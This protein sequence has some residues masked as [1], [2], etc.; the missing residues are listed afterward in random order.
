LLHIRKL[1][2]VGFKSFA[3]RTELTFAGSGIAGIVGP[4]GC[5][6]SNIADAISW[7][8]GEQSVKSLRGQRMEDVIFGGT[9]DRAAT[10]MAEVSLTLVD[11]EVFN[12]P[13]DLEDVATDTDDEWE[14]V[15]EEAEVEETG[16]EDEKQL[17]ANSFEI[18][19][20]AAVESKK[21]QGDPHG[22]GNAATTGAPLV[23][24][25]R[26]RR[27]F[28]ANNRPG[29]VVVTRR[30]FRSGESEYLMNGRP[31]RLRDIQDLFMGTG[32]GPESY[33]IIE[34][35]RVGQILSS[36]SYDRRALIEEAAGITKYKARK[37]LAETRLEQAR[38]NLSRIN[39]IFEE[40]TR[41]MTS[42]KRQAAKARRYSDLRKELDQHQRRL[43]FSRAR[44][45][46]A[47]NARVTVEHESVRAESEASYRSLA[48]LESD[49]SQWIQATGNLEQQM[50]ATTQH[51]GE[52]A[53]R[54]DRAERQSEFNRTQSAQ[55][56]QQIAAAELELAGLGEQRAAHEREFAAAEVEVGQVEAEAET[57]ARGCRQIR[58]QSATEARQMQ[59]LEQTSRLAR[60][61]VFAA[62]GEISS[63]GNQ[64]TQCETLLA[65]IERQLARIEA[66]RMAGVRELEELGVRSGQISLTFETERTELESLRDDIARAE[67]RAR[68]LA[69][70]ATR[71]RASLD[72]ARAELATVAA[73][74]H[75]LREIV[76]HHGYS[77][78]AVQK[79][80]SSAREKFQPLGVL[81][82]FLEVD[83]LYE[84]VVEE[85][86]REELNFVVV[87]DW[88]DAGT[89]IGLLQHDVQGRATFLIHPQRDRQ[90]RMFEA[91]AGDLNSPPASAHPVPLKECVRVLDGFGRTLEHILPKLG[92]G[93]ILEDTSVARDMAR[94]NPGAYFLTPAG[95]CFHNQT[96]TG[97][98]RAATGPLSLKR[99]LRELALRE[100]EL[101]LAAAAGQQLLVNVEHE[102]AALRERIQGMTAHRHSLETEHAT[103]AQAL[104]QLEDEV[105]R[106][107]ERVRLHSLEYDRGRF[108]RNEASERLA[109]LAEEREAAERRRVEAEA[110]E[111]TLASAS[112]NARANREQ[113]VRRLAEA[114]T[115]VARLDERLRTTKQT[116][117][118]LAQ[119]VAEVD[120]RLRQ[121]ESHLH[122]ARQRLEQ[123]A[124]ESIALDAERNEA[125]QQRQLAEQERI[126]L[127]QELTTAHRRSQELETAVTTARAELEAHRQKQ[128]EIELVLA[129]LQSDARHLAETCI[130]EL[131]CELETLLQA[132][133]EP[134]ASEELAGLDQAV[135]DLRVRIE[136][137]G[138]VN[139]MALEEFEE[140]QQRHQ[141]LES[142]RKDLLD[143]IA[144]TQKAIEEIDAVCREQFN[145]AFEKINTF[146]QENF[147]TMFGGGQGF[148]RLTD[149]ENNPDGGV[150]IVAQPPGKKLQNALLLS[151]GE[152]AMAAMALLFA[153]FRFQPSPFCVLDEVDAPLDDA[154]IGRFTAMI[155]H[156]SDQ[157]QFIT[158]THNKRT[159]EAASMLY[160]VT[161]PQPG[162]SRLVSVRM[163]GRMA[164]AAG[165]SA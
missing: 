1:Q 154:N 22:N 130:A 23:L 103:S 96:V 107:N 88:T 106:A 85:F 135:R 39:D 61:R 89:G 25:V 118:R 110:E 157:T 95:E 91:P 86:L 36:K 115:L 153:V 70:Q 19:P 80:F 116:R 14:T 84:R 66:E 146:F 29:E 109:R 141:F 62:M 60:Q 158:I 51:I 63:L 32:L 21:A 125:E 44:A 120:A 117:D 55:I 126:R 82:D 133:I 10:G 83:P 3:D 92:S 108:E 45:I 140:T 139:M 145:T 17:S 114:E 127:E 100:E 129:R 143:S 53:L 78:E 131:N 98:T 35:G 75:S 57:A 68:E 164:V 132:E 50:L 73:R 31:C 74:S 101:Q 162:I 124:A 105:Q 123:L 138:P 155:A 102:L 94:E 147:K 65:G 152:K 30:L 99:E 18:R 137:L 59:E 87:Q 33:A 42:L 16:E 81:A 142:Q 134:A 43:L 47:E 163:D 148:L 4:N 64:A 159:M 72:A 77:T 113:T 144:D 48:A 11:P 58:E 161:M 56:E 122:G 38:Q 104:R 46:E 12:G 34:Q 15:A 6:K 52:F 40:V 13:D 20:A 9:R 90:Y 150:D 5:G 149:A 69:E 28:R 41:Q 49:R 26:K 111:A 119:A 156:L 67:A 76:S 151:G 93:Y 37:K 136:N 79:L 54:S 8:L 71:A 160:G 128:N 112:E 165:R 24:T 121:T 7:V 27:R 97:G 2:V